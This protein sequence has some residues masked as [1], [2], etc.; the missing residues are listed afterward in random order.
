MA[1][2]QELDIAILGRLDPSVMAAVNAAKAQLKSIGADARTSSEVMKRLYSQMFDGMGKSA[3][4]GES[5]VKGVFHRM[6]E[7]AQHAAHAI[8]HSFSHA[9][10]EIG[11]EVMK[12]IGFGAG[13]SIVGN[14]AQ[15]VEGA[16]EA[17]KEF[18]KG[19]AE[20]HAER[21]SMQATIHS[22]LSSK[23]RASQA[24]EMDTMFRQFEGQKGPETYQQL[25]QATMQLLGAAPERFKT[26]AS[27]ETQL[28]HL[29][30]VSRD[31]L[32]FSGVT[33]AYTRILAEGKVDAAHLR[34]MSVDTGFNFKKA[35]ADALKVTPE[36]LSKMIK[37]GKLSGE[38]SIEAL[39]KGMELITGPGGA[40]Y[41]HAEAQLQGLS[42]IFKRFEGHFQDFQ[43]SFGM[44]LEN[45]LRPI[46]NTVFRY[47]T[48]SELTHAFDRFKGM[49]EGF[50]RSISYLIEAFG[51]PENAQRFKDLGNAVQGFF[52]KA[53]NIGNTA[54]FKTITG[55]ISGIGEQTILS[56][57]WR[58]KLDQLTSTVSNAAETLGGM[59]KSIT[60]NW[61][62]IQKGMLLVAE[63]WGAAKIAGWVK[64]IAEFFG[65]VP[66]I[67]T[68]AINAGVINTGVAAGGIP[69][70]GTG[71]AVA[72]GEEAAG[73]A[74]GATLLSRLGLVGGVASVTLVELMAAYGVTKMADV[75]GDALIKKFLPDLGKGQ[76]VK[77]EEYR[78]IQQGEEQARAQGV[79][80]AKL[81]RFQE[82]LDN[83]WKS[84]S[85]AE[86]ESFYAPARAKAMKASLIPQPD[87]RTRGEISPPGE[88]K[89]RGSLDGVSNS[90][91]ALPEKASGIS[92][93]LESVASTFSGLPSK[94]SAVSAAMDSFV[95]AIN[96]AVAKANA[97]LSSI[98]TVHA[99]DMLV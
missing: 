35:M 53:F 25:S 8:Q 44:Q 1:K 95:A 39:M 26:V 99:A 9:F 94:A 83:F 61:G 91:A 46:A 81:A 55:G 49:A 71:G 32:A 23:G 92:G 69:A 5:E 58:T 86:Q 30:D 11:T 66:Y 73:G 82:T 42:G 87:I 20:I 67:N 51:K 90:F 93:N 3:K 7:E 60:D 33:Q 43:D 24:E 72:A 64:G 78:R 59:I 21:E 17:T 18:A 40:A 88:D 28:Q 75:V 74:G 37:T 6:V 27:V 77:G 12:G 54:M 56:P 31:P 70:A 38:Q 13:F 22:I 14:I 80:P 52:A 19:A 85:K 63:V 76:T 4:K 96:S 41:G 47:L 15:G 45:F 97:S 10:H 98:A 68:A 62:N 16:M 34:E 48:P 65:A 89:I 2:E 50:G 84:M 57:E 36:Q 29:A 79:S